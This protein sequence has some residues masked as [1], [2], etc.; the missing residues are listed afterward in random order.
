MNE[1]LNIYEYLDYRSFLKDYYKYMKSQN[2]GFSYRF[3]AKIA[4]LKTENYLKLVID[5]KIHL[6]NKIRRKFAKACNFN[7]EEK[8]FFYLLI[9]FARSKDFKKKNQIFKRISKRIKFINQKKIGIDQYKIL[10]KWYYL[11]VRS[12]ISIKGID[13]DIKSLSKIMNGY[14]TPAQIKE[15]IELLLDLNFIRENENGY[16]L[17]DR[18]I[19]AE[20]DA[21]ADAIRNFHSQMIPI[22]ALAVKKNDVNEREIRAI[23]L[24]LTKINAKEVK[25]LIRN[26]YKDLVSY[27]SQENE[28]KTAEEVWQLNFQFF[29]FTKER[30][31]E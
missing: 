17:C 20:D 21:Q 26:F 9:D 14:L 10:S 28:I 19:I 15:S 6:S 8:E 7:V 12:L 11:V 27:L 18:N 1:K 23:T 22:G 24:G 4:K 13:N 5:R 29:K 16:E 25:T 2:V 31:N 3:F 30:K